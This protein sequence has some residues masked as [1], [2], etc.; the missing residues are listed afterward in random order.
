ML[1]Q[2]V[3]TAL[4][5][6][7]S[8]LLW[9]QFAPDWLFACITGLVTLLG[10]FEWAR[11]SGLCT[12][13]SQ[14]MYACFFL[15]LLLGVTFLPDPFSIMQLLSGMVMFWIGMLSLVLQY[16]E[17]FPRWLHKIGL[18]AFLGI[19]VLLPAYLGLQFIRSTWGPAAIF[20]LF[21]IIWSADIGAYFAGRTFGRHRLA[22]RISPGKTWEGLIGGVILTLLV[23]GLLFPSVP[24]SI[25]LESWLFIS[26]LTALAGV[27]GDLLESL[28][29]RI[30]GVKDSGTLLPGHGGILDRIDSLT[31]AVPVFTVLCLLIGE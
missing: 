2:R 17:G 29:K 8:A 15:G 10:A 25:S 18:R 30:A 19:G 20:M 31:A 23:G 1:K 24:F 28:M 26:V 27:L 11:L 4:W 16:R 13:Y 9:V 6:I 12:K 3:R 5:L 14:Q 22:P 7:P 21:A